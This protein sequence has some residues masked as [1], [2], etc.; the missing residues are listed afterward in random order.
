LP[1]SKYNR[2]YALPPAGF[3]RQKVEV[4]A[5]S[6]DGENPTTAGQEEFLRLRQKVAEL[7]RQVG[8]SRR[9]V[10]R[11]SVR[12][13]VTSALAESSSLVEAAP[14]MLRAVCETL[15][16]QIGA[17]WTVE[18]HLDLLRCVEI[19]HAPDVSVPAFEAATRQLTC[20]RGVGMPGRV[21]GSAQ[22]A[23]IPDVTKDENFP[24]A[25]IAAGEGLR[26]S[27]GF[28][29][30][31]GA[32]CVGVMEFFSREI[33]QPD[34]GLLEMLAALGSQIG[35]YVERKHAERELDRYFTLSL[36][37]LCIATYDGYFIRVNPAWERTLGYTAQ[38]MTTS[39][40]LDFV[41][42]EDRA[43]TL[44]EMESLSKGE[45]TISFENR[46]RAKDGSYHWML[47]NATPFA[48]EQLIYAAAR[49]I[50]GRKRDE[51]KILH[52]REE[53]ETANQ[54]KSEFL[55]R[56]SH[57]IR[58]PLNVVIGMGDVLEQTALNTEQRQYVRVLQKAGGELLMRINDLLDL[59]KAE[60]GRITLEEI[61]FK[62][63]DVLEA[64]VDIM[65]MRAQQKRIELRA[66]IG[67][68]LSM[69]RGDPDRLRQVLINLVA[70]AI[71]FTDKGRVV[72]RAEPD[73]E[74][75]EPGAL[76][77][78]VSD[79]GIGIPPEKLDSIFEAFAQGHASTTRKYGGT[80]LGLAISK[81]LVELMN[82][83]IWAESH[84][85]GGTTFYFTAQFGP[86]GPAIHPHIEGT[87]E[88]DL[89]QSVG[90][91]P[92]LRILV[93]DDS[94]ENRFLV[95]EYLKDLG[96]EID[97]AEDGQIAVEKFCSG[98]YGL[99]LMDLQM[100]V[101]DGLAATR[102]IRGW[103]EE[104]GRPPTPILALT[105]STLSGELQHAL[106]AGCTAYLRKPV[107]LLTLVEAVGKYAAKT[108]ARET[109]S[110]NRVQVRADD[111]LR[112]VIPGYLQ[113]RRGDVRAIRE[114]LERN[115]FDK[116]RELGHKMHGSGSGYG[117]P[118]ITEIGQALEDAGRE[119]SAD[120]IH[121]R[122]IELS[123][124]LDRIEVV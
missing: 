121:A 42:P 75:P 9:D 90:A 50:T 115:D 8:E 1:E 120:A 45:D 91:F 28:P 23:W 34:R 55:A 106:D 51:A 114:A 96:C 119:H 67:E 99:V 82:G 47:W 11:F 92:G 69:L 73:P 48:Q 102:R 32:H 122:I 44:A 2:G 110:L 98:A 33:R 105:A 26:A 89:T 20:E 87:E 113:N 53:A 71:K 117:F 38:E 104:Q 10:Q 54:A 21:W 30:T 6:A 60:A 85:S 86:A 35:Q 29:I 4:T 56:M 14:R 118:R 62:L 24:R 17:L 64:V 18:Q 40:F 123:T 70:N 112:A 57:E 101:M 83:R 111:R 61:D 27:L 77:F 94:E 107:R 7:E 68:A 124:Y 84:P 93:A 49:D 46:Y 25:R 80:G 79:T 66:E 31:A 88:A 19:W 52:L 100:P 36:D 74:R 116:I 76:R 13:A 109:A 81:R 16:W 63:S 3:Q 97:S 95:V 72:L 5:L 58:T 39:P 59:S 15:E 22:P 37:M 78:S 65:L 41:H 103:E 108:T 12:D 43:A